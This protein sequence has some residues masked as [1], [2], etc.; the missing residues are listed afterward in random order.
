MPPKP[1]SDPDSVLNIDF[2]KL[3]LGKGNRQASNN[4]NQL[5]DPFIKPHLPTPSND[6]PN[7]TAPIKLTR[8]HINVAST[9][10]N[11]WFYPYTKEQFEAKYKQMRDDAQ[12]AGKKGLQ[13]HAPV[14]HG[15]SE[16]C[17]VTHHK[18][19][20]QRSPSRG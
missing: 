3:H 10:D 12:K 9:F 20:L 4:K 17:K 7:G 2:S 11:I 8:P 1:D 14:D 16:P 6:P 19:L 15:T 5:T 18:P 13:A